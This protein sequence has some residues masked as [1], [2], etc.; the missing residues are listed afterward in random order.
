MSDLD[1]WP[2]ALL[3]VAVVGAWNP[4]PV[5]V[6]AAAFA[7]VGAVLLR[8]RVLLAIAVLAL[9]SGLGHRALAGL[10]GLE[11]HDVAASVTLLTDPRPELGGGV[12]AEG[13]LG[14]RR[15]EVEARHV[16]A[17]ALAPRLAGDVVRIRGT[18]GPLPRP[19]D[20]SRSRH[21]AGRLRILAVEGWTPGHPV[22]AVANGV[23]RTLVRGT[24][25]MSRAERSLFTGLVV[26]DDREQPLVLAD[27]FQ[28]AGLTHLLAVS[29]QNVA[30]VLALASPA[31]RRLRLWPRLVLAVALIGLFATVTRF[32]PSVVRA[33]AMAV[34]ALVATTAGSPLARLQVLGL[35][36]A[37]IVLVDPL[38]VRSVGFQLSAAATAA[39]VL[40]APGLEA[41]LPGPAWLRA[42]LAV[43]GAAQLGVAPILV[44]T[45]GPLPVASL[46]ANLLAV[47]AAGLVMAWGLT[48]GLLAGGL[49]G[50]GAPGAAGVAGLL[51]L[52]TRLLLAWV[53]EVASRSAALPLGYLGVPHLWV[54]SLAL[55]VAVMA[56]R[57]AGSTAEAS[58]SGP[59]D[60]WDATTPADTATS[61]L[62]RTPDRIRHLGRTVAGGVAALTLVVAAVGAHAP[63]GLRSE[64]LPG[65]VRWHAAGSD[66]LVLGGAGGRA[67]IRADA[68]L[69][70]LREV[71]VDALEMVVLADSGASPSLVETLA[72]RHP[73]GVVIAHDAAEPSS[74]R[75]S[76]RLEVVGA[77][78]RRQTARVGGLEVIF[79]PTS[80]R[81]VV[82]ARRAG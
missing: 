19:S 65:V 14:E 81:L 9:A 71:G 78:I 48:G 40:A 38:L 67:H 10:G 37:A 62:D 4:R 47:P 75:A 5:P 8:R 27:D 66:V 51:H 32:E 46:P 18:L 55:V 41:V 79:T 15:V 74:W 30:F 43:T 39:I 80:D 64:L 52:P 50:I 36:L 13:R 56:A 22:G 26:G 7:V 49:V 1:R 61:E 24:G 25:S 53:A 44:T 16:A 31:L 82:E 73:I 58:R 29:G 54:I 59:L 69:E 12:R 57:P 70:R 72:R 21:L 6:L 33:S 77:P 63:V 28:G 20:W 35:A 60:G 2:L 11:E 45:F 42:P 68:L 34:L 23:R 76:A 3:V 17:G